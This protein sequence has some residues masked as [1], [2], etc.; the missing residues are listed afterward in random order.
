M[1]MMEPKYCMLHFALD[2]CAQELCQWN[3]RVK[4]CEFSFRPAIET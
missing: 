4:K 1:A 2:L 3:D